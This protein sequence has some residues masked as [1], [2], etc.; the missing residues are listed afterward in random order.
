MKCGMCGGKTSTTFYLQ[1][2]IPGSTKVWGGPSPD[3]IDLCWEDTLKLNLA[4][5]GAIEGAITLAHSSM[6]VAEAE[7]AEWAT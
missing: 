4:A 5:R 3:T 6:V 2:H 7:V 1:L